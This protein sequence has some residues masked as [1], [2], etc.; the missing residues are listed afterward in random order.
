MT[1]QRVV[2][3]LGSRAGDGP[4]LT[5]EDMA[6]ARSLAVVA[7]GWPL[8]PHQGR[9][10]A[11][12]LTLARSTGVVLEAIL[13][14]SAREATTHVTDQDR[15]LVGG[16]SRDRRRIRRALGARGLHIA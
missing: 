2:L 3:L 15:I 12:A 10:V 13:A 5:H 4:Y 7:I 9:V 1:D 11:E 14:A 16:S 6:S 8:T